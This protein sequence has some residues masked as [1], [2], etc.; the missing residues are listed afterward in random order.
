M[1][2]GTAW[3]D[4]DEFVGISLEVFIVAF[5]ALCWAAALKRNAATRSFFHAAATPVDAEEFKRLQRRKMK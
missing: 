5:D 4:F 2:G 3:A 1:I